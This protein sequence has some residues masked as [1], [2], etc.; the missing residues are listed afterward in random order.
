[1]HLAFDIRHK[2][3]LLVFQ[4]AFQRRV[5]CRAKPD[6]MRREPQKCENALLS[7]RTN[8]QLR[9]RGRERE[10]AARSL[11]SWI[12]YSDSPDAVYVRLKRK[13]IDCKVL[14]Q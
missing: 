5:L 8:T 6:V 9:E 1:M 11:L 14:S 13:N 3:S 4:L 2:S 12:I 7:T 10:K